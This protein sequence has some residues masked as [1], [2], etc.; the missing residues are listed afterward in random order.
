MLHI[1]DLAIGGDMDIFQ[2]AHDVGQ[3]VRRERVGQSITQAALAK[4]SGVSRDWLIRFENGAD[5]QELSKV[6]SVLSSLG[7]CLSPSPK[8]APIHDPIID[9]IFDSLRRD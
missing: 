7:L 2:N 4:Q 8:P 1:C 3:F 5:G 9:R 6:F